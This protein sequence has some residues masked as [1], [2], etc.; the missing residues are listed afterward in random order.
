MRTLFALLVLA[1]PAS[2]AGGWGTLDAGGEQ[3]EVYRDS[4]GIPHLF[5]KTVR[6]VF[7]AEGYTEAQDRMWQMETFRRAAKGESA[8]LQGQAGLANDRDRLRRGYTEAELRKQYEAC[9]E[10][11]RAILDAYAAGVNAWIAEGKDL[12]P[13]YGKLGVKPRP[14][15]VTDS[16]AIGVLMARRF[17]EAGDIELTMVR[18]RDELVKK[19]GAED[20]DRIL[21]DLLKQDDP[22]APATLHDHLRTK[23]AAP[24]REKGMRPAPGMGDGAYAAYRAE[25]E[26]VFASRES[27][28]VPTYFGSNAWVIHGK[29]TATGNPIL[30]GGPMMGFGAPAICNEVHLVAE[31]LN[32]AGMSFPGAPGVMIGWNDRVAWTTT[33]GGADL[34]DVFTL[35]LNP[36]NPDEYRYQGAWKKFEILDREIKVLD[37]KTEKLKVYRSV[38]GPLAGERDLKNHRAHTLRMSFWMQEHRTVEGVFDMN[39]SKS[40]AEFEAGAEKVVTSHNFF[41]ATADGHIGF[42]FCG[43]HPKR[44]KGHV[45]HLPQDGGGAMDWE[46]ILEPKEWPRSVDPARGFFGNWNN[47]AGRDW[48]CY[49]YGKIFWGK[50]IL[51]VLEAEPKITFGKV[52]DLA[53]LTAYHSF[54]ADYFKPFILEAGKGSED[55]EVKR[56]VE[57]L[58]KWDHMEREGEIAPTI[59]RRWVLGMMRRLF[60]GFVDPIMLATEE[61]Q[62]FAVD[63]LLYTFE[64]EA[65]LVKLQYD[66]AK[67]KDL[68]ALALDALKEAAKGDVAALAWKEPT[69][70][71]KGEI[72]K[73]KSKKGRGTYQMTVEMTPQGPRAATSSAP[74]QSERPDSKHYKDQRPH[75]EKWEYK[76]FATDR[77]AMK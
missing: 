37:G 73:L 4:F 41:C 44:K 52:S 1:S 77:A 6:A 60:G 25:L 16:I 74:G 42:W 24:P 55:P 69:V 66:Y 20:A 15:D 49:G 64:G 61:V 13:D 31:G 40:L 72:G 57:A 56:A 32:A 28:G 48:P 76:P 33:S 54:L 29:R 53:R 22:S 30:Y 26:E 35:E 5:A 34:V 47:K 36:E 7:W 39:F 67:G 68:K 50:K 11:V 18:V 45:A 19:V 58:E 43:M 8:E 14:W 71:F 75:F 10:K 17:G 62:R 51:D 3:V 27:L 65:C 21:A 9:T 59:V 46:G 12:P 70:D 2:Q 23:A 38:H 63:P